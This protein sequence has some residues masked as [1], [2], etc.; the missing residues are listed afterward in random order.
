MSAK[1]IQHSLEAQERILKKLRDG[2][3]P[4]LEEIA[5]FRIKPN[6]DPETSWLCAV[7]DRDFMG[8]LHQSLHEVGDLLEKYDSFYSLY[9]STQVMIESSAITIDIDNRTNVLYAWYNTLNDVDEKLQQLCSYFEL[10]NDSKRKSSS[11][12]PRLSSS[13]STSSSSKLD[14]MWPRLS[15]EADTDV[16]MVIN[17]ILNIEYCFPGTD[18]RQQF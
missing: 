7:Y 18:G 3:C 10:L 8:L 13:S 14:K 16:D 11:S 17:Y 1:V 9:P 4:V 6:H 2:K 15:S 12:L 5:S